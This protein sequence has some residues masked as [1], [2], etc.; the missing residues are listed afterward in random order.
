MGQHKCPFTGEGPSHA[1][2][3]LIPVYDPSPLPPLRSMAWEGVCPLMPENYTNRLLT[4]EIF[5][6][7]VD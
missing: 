3:N 1:M 2:A 7:I 4:R 6:E 5:P